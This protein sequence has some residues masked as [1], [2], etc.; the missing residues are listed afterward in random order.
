ML[1]PLDE[2]PELRAAMPVSPTSSFGS[3]LATLL[4]TAFTR[5]S[6]PSPLLGGA[7]KYA[8]VVRPFDVTKLA[9]FVLAR[10]TIRTSGFARR[11]AENAD[12]IAAC[13]PLTLCPDATVTTSTAG[14]VLPPLP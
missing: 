10:S 2:P 6:A 12:A 3:A 4:S 9:S 13:S 7:N 8:N 5:L 1:G 14:V 11:A